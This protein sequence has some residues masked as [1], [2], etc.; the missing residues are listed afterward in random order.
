[1]TAIP[2][3]RPGPGRLVWLLCLLVGCATGE[4]DRPVTTGDVLSAD[5]V[6]IRYEAR[7]R[8]DPAIVLVHGWTNSRRIWGDHPKT[9][10]RSNRVV[11]LDLAGHG[12]SGAGR[13]EWTMD[14]FGEDVVAVVERLGLEDVVLV[15]FSMGGAVVLE[16]A[17][18]L[19]ERVLGVVFVDTFH[20]PDKTL[21]PSQVE[22]LGARFRAAWGDTTFVRAFAFTPE[23]PDSLIA[24][25]A[26]MMPD[27]PRDHWFPALRAHAEWVRSELRPTLRRIDAPV[28]AINTTREPT[29]VAAIRRYAPSFTVDT[30]GGVGHAGILLRRVDE[31]DRKLLALVDRF[32]GERPS[33]NR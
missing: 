14:A 25:V 23:A 28:A 22:G 11:V 13:T 31:F 20:D 29:N 18:R 32:Q 17:E 6:S 21:A 16:A 24:Y 4:P 19:P 1:M 10:S 33:R 3:V 12:E 8:G 2:I 27:R 15:G 9:L 26:G 7:G 5:G 30:L